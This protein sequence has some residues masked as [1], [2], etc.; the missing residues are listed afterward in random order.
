MFYC[1]CFIGKNKTKNTNF[2]FIFIF[3]VKMANPPNPTPRSTVTVSKINWTDHLDLVFLNC[4]FKTKAHKRTKGKGSSYEDKYV[5]VIQQMWS[6]PD[7]TFAAYERPDWTTLQA[8]YK[9][10][11]SKMRAKGVQDGANLSGLEAMTEVE[12]LTDDMCKDEADTLDEKDEADETERKKQQNLLFIEAQLK[13]GTSSKF[14]NGKKTNAGKRNS[15]S[16]ELDASEDDEAAEEAEVRTDGGMD[17]RPAE[18]TPLK[19]E[20]T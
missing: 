16:T 10:M 5:K 20:N 4:V 13:T 1:C 11:A 6:L 8:K 3:L 14:A 17:P 12:K 2:C 7:K 9:R 19:Q 18:P 15:K